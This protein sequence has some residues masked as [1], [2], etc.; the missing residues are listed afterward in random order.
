[1]KPIEGNL[2]GVKAYRALLSLAFEHKIY[3]VIA[4][5]GMV[6]FAASDAAFAY[7]M[8]P[9]MDD[10]FIDRDPTI[11]KYMP[12]AIVAIFVVR[13]FAVFMRSY[14]M[15]Y[16][17]RNVINRLRQMMFEKLLTMTS[18]EYDQS[19]TATI[20]ARF[21][22]DVEQVAKSVSS[23]L[24][25]FIQDSLRIIVLLGY[26]IWL[27]WQLT[28]IFLIAGPIVFL[29]VV[30]ISGRF[31][32]ISRSIQRS[33]GG[34]TQVAQEVIDGNRIVKIFGGDEFERNKFQRRNKANLKLHLKMTIAQAVSMPLIQ[35]VVAIAFATI[36]AFA[37]SE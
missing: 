3:F 11:I 23:S 31:R 37:T 13:M 22:Y 6:I 35:L 9:L 21:S 8:K 14:C 29:I 19:S 2:T 12:V 4:V 5:I 10:G 18:D 20:V 26:M 15:S 28:A 7:L 25:V 32:G 24:T 16:I 34:V 30:R 17:G 33:M 36:I 1:M 27:N